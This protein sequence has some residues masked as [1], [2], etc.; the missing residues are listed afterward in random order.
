MTLRELH[1]SL[2]VD[3]AKKGQAMLESKIG[4]YNHRYDEDTTNIDK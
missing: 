4:N 2:E 3:V 1:A